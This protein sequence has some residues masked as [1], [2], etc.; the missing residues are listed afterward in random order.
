MRIAFDDRSTFA[1]RYSARCACNRLTGYNDKQIDSA[2]RT[3]TEYSRGTEY[4]SGRYSEHLSLLLALMRA[5][6]VLVWHRQNWNILRPY[7]PSVF[8]S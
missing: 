1:L 5:L 4:S 2:E 7:E 8:Q 6:P 3:G